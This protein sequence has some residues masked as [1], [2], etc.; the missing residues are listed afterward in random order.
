MTAKKAITLAM[1]ALLATLLIG[2][3]VAVAAPT[4]DAPTA[5]SPG[6]FARIGSAIHEA[7]ARGI[8]VLADLTGLD[9]TEIAERRS[10]GE[11]A[12]SIV[13]SEG[14]SKDALV[15]EMLDRRAA[16]LDARVA[17]GLIT[18][19]QADEM[20]TRMQERITERVTSEEHGKPADRGH[21]YG[22]G[23]GLGAGAGQG[24]GGGRG[25][26]GYGGECPVAE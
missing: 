25:M 15:T 7:G 21:G 5:E 3:G 24:A 2:T 23:M 20:L 1:A 22:Q 11:S 18:Q 13:E 16:M 19:E 8:D 6:I 17:D 12:A 4:Q 10:D 26:G 9:L 14:L